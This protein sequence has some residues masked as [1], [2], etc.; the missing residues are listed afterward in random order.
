MRLSLVVML[1]GAAF[2]AAALA[3]FLTGSSAS[4]LVSAVSSAMSKLSSATPIALKPGENISFI[5]AE[6]AVI[7]VNSSVP[8]KVVPS[9]VQVRY[10]NGIEVVVAPPNVTV[11]IVNNYT[12]PVP[13]AHASIQISPSVSSAVFYLFISVGLGFLGFVLLVIGAVMYALRR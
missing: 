12:A 9:G 6:P 11:Y 3:L 13:L 5:Y 10:Q 7:L 2:M 1:M 8:L 4:S